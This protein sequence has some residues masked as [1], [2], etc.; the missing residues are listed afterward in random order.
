MENKS[1]FTMPEPAE[2]FGSY[3]AWNYD[4]ET[5]II[6]FMNGSQYMYLLEGSQ[7]ALLIDT[8]YGTGTL[9]RFAETLT[10][11][12]L[13][14]V[15][16]HF[17]PDH[18]GGN[19]E[20]E[21]VYVACGWETD[22]PSVNDGDYPFDLNSLP[23][24]NY[25]KKIVKDGEKIDLGERSVEIIGALPAHCNSSLFLLDESHGMLF[26]GDEYETAQT[27]MIDNSHNPAA[28]Y[29]V[30][31]RIENLKANAVR[32]KE[33][34]EKY[35]FLFPNHNG[36]P[37]SKSYLDDYIELCDSILE[38]CCKIENKLNHKYLE[39]DPRADHMCRVR[40]GKVSIIILKEELARI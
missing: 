5:W 13:E 28:P 27:I 21:E 40:Y 25:Y 6:S 33:F 17:H 7:K 23:Y 37:A 35:D 11:K 31:T 16:T 24:P 30:R 26:T 22:A 36:A 39:M 2:I 15:N 8:G 9:R 18:S 4:P 19:G 29:H 10:D 20:F 38:H 12:K 32:L 3:T 34:D 1:E 14:V